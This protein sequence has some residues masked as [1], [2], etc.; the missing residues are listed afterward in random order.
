MEFKT[1]P[2]VGEW[3]QG[4]DG[5]NFEIVAIDKEERT[6]EIQYFD[7][8]IEE[9]DFSSWAQLPMQ[10]SDP[11]EDWSGPMDMMREDYVSDS[12]ISSHESWANPL[13]VL[14]EMDSLALD[15]Y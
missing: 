15:E 1:K 2:V 14:D 7:G 6:I 10:P 5:A 8:A 3:Y 13:D 4:I 9:L 11:P 12:T